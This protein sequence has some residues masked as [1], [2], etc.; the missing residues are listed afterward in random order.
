MSDNP[1]DRIPTFDRL[2]LRAVVV[3]EGEDPGPALAAAGIVEPIELPIVFGEDPPDRT[4]GD[5]LTPNITAVLEQD[6]S[7]GS[8]S[9]HDPMVSQ[10]DGAAGSDAGDISQSPSAPSMPTA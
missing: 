4:F 3:P 2:S 7:D 1:L 5:G 6:Q 9:Q 8:A 10:R